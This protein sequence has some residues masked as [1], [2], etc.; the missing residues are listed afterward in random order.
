MF[1]YYSLI[2][3]LATYKVF[4][5]FAM[6]SVT[7]CTVG[8]VCSFRVDQIFVHFVSFLVYQLLYT[9][10]KCLKYNIFS[11]WFLDTRISTCFCMLFRFYSTYNDLY[12]SMHIHHYSGLCRFKD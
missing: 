7:V 9:L 5:C 8:Y 11:V 3:R 12:K 10:L 6:L 2:K 4:L 1:I